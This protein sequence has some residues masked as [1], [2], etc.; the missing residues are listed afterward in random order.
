[1]VIVKTVTFHK[2]LYLILADILEL[3]IRLWRYLIISSRNAY[4]FVQYFV[5]FFF[6][7]LIP[8]HQPEVGK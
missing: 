3:Y 4:N 2:I 5:M 1:M 8:S 6:N 7:I